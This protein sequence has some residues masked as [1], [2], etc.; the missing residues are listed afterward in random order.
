MTRVASVQAAFDA[1]LAGVVHGRSEPPP[2]DTPGEL[3]LAYFVGAHGWHG[4]VVEAGRVRA[5]AMGDVDATAARDALSTKLLAPFDS[6]L[7][8]ARRIAVLAYDA[9]RS[10]DVHALPWRGAPL[11]A[12]VGVVYPL[13]RAARGASLDT[14]ASPRV[15]LVADPTSDLKGA[16]A[17]LE[18][19]ANA[20]TNSGGWAVTVLRDKRATGDAVRSGLASADLFH[21]AG[22]GRFAGRDGW[23]SAL[24]LAEHGELSVA[25][26]LALP[27]APR[28]VFLLGC[29]TA[30]D[31]G[32]ADGQGLGLA[33]AFLVVGARA[34]VAASRPVDDAATAAIATEIY[35]RLTTEVDVAETM[36]AVVAAATARG[37]T[38][39][40]AFRVLAP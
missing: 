27:R 5:V 15:L 38:G 4:F 13:D 40:D 16:R 1:A 8:R 14:I 35:A 34:V 32:E 19:V 30:R 12:A 29:D 2:L 9:A 3:T 22:H 7:G 24:R 18:S 17:E 6:E 20:L 31:S 28:A 26:I 10:V 33:Q 21:Y 23:A 36:R 11:G 25:D 37:L 39:W